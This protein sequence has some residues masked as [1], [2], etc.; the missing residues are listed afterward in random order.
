[1]KEY[2]AC[3]GMSGK[4]YLKKMEERK[5]KLKKKDPMKIFNKKTSKKSKY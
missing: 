2:S 3:V 4:D 1:M 5:E